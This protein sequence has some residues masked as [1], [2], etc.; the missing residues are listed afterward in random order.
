MNSSVCLLIVQ[1]VFMSRILLLG[2]TG[3]LGSSLSSILK[4][5]N[6]E[7]ICQ[8]RTFGTDI[9]LDLSDNLAWQDC[10]VTLKPDV[11]INLAAATDVDKCEMN[12]QWAFDANVASILTFKKAANNTKIKPHMIYVSTDQLYDGIGPHRECDAR[13]SNVYGLSK[14]SGELALSNYPST[15]FRTNF[16]GLSRSPNRLS[17]SDWI[18]RSVQSGK[19]ITLFR[20]VLFSP[21]HISTLCEYLS[22]AVERKSIG[23]YNVGSLDGCSKADFGL[24]L[25]TKLNI[26]ASEIRIGSVK[27]LSLQARRPNDM[28]MNSSLFEKD[29]D[30]RMPDIIAE[31]DKAS[32]EYHG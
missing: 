19:Q 15:I 25:A 27:D 20:D 1:C 2:A 8:S 16:F 5:Y 17:F 32:H 6:H 26:D 10:L 3:L 9:K 24:Q 31:I 4:S 28:R 23:V 30:V 22:L 12:P 11:I 21:L 29:F 18:V 13:P 7:V 14:L